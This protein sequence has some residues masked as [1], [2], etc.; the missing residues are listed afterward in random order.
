MRVAI[1]AECFLPE[2]NGVTNS[3]MRV[4]AHLER[5]GHEALVIAPG[6]GPARYL[7][8]PVERV[9][10]MPLPMYRSLPIG[11]PTG[12]AARILADFRPDVVHLAAPAVLGAEAGRAACALDVPVVAVYQT[13]FAGFAR[14]YGLGSMRPVIWELVRR[15]H[16]HATLTLAPSTSVAWELEARGVTPV[17][18]WARGVDGRL[19]HPRRRRI[20]LRRQLAPDGQLIVGYV[21]RLASEKQVGLL[22]HLEGVP[23]IRLVIVGDGPTRGRLERQLP[24]ARFLGF[25]SGVELAEAVA[26]LDVFVHTG[27]HETFCQAVQEA[28]AS[29]VPVVAPAS[30]GLLD[31]VRHGVNGWLFP[32]GRPDLM[33]GAVIDLVSDPA[34]RLAMGTRA[35]TTVEHRTWE[36]LGD[37]LLHHY[38]TVAGHEEAEC[39]AA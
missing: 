10:A 35:R 6:I 27:S 19:F 18:L 17:A 4:V 9:P 28:L 34:T 16:R 24:E 15:V 2:H 38:R 13:D 1:A 11:L 23:G 12:R 20:L 3:V 5:R 36:V 14:R 30:G 33:R 39:Q 8:T 29:G 31:L 21:G 7:N 26:S 32:P 22:R 37:Q 25:R